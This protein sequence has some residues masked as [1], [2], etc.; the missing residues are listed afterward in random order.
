MLGTFF[1]LGVDLEVLRSAYLRNWGENSAGD[2]ILRATR[3]DVSKSSAR[4]A[5]KITERRNCK[6][7][8]LLQKLVGHWCVLAPQ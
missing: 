7:F 5:A 1:A 4:V 3:D 2:A 8:Y 6:C